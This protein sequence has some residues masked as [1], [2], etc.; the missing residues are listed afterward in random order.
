MQSFKNFK[1]IFLEFEMEKQNMEY[2]DGRQK[3]IHYYRACYL[4]RARAM[5]RV[6]RAD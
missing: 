3:I 6:V 1:N 4:A 5:A 2:I